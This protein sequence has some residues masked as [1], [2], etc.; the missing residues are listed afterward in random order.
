M[1]H[2]DVILKDPKILPLKGAAAPP[3]ATLSVRK[4]INSEWMQKAPIFENNARELTS[5]VCADL[6]VH[7]LPVQT[8]RAKP[9]V[10]LGGKNTSVGIHKHWQNWI[11]QVEGHK[12]WFL[13]RP[14]TE[15]PQLI[16]DPC[17]YDQMQLNGKTSVQHCI[18]RPGDIIYLPSNWWHATCNLDNWNF[19]FGAEGDTAKMPAAHL[20]VLDNDVA[21]LR[22]AVAM[23]GKTVLE[24]EQ[25]V[26]RWGR[27]RP[28]DSPGKGGEPTP[29]QSKI[30]QQATCRNSGRVHELDP[31][32]VGPRGLLET[33]RPPRRHTK[34][35]H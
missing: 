26:F 25:L 19:G 34:T 30:P 15:K 29:L 16:D 12:A 6:D 2:L 17:A 1:G 28:A 11:A 20:A 7:A 35:S 5:A 31:I 24:E 8:V 10:S 27:V 18:A 33:L 14:G 23:G 4:Y 22:R 32:G 13:A 9:I 21:A 3:I